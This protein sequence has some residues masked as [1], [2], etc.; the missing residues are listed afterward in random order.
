MKHLLTLSPLALTFP[1]HAI[2]SAPLR[3]NILYVVAD[4]LGYADLGVQGSI[5]VPT[6][7][8]DSIA[9][10]G[11]RFTHGYVSAPV[12]SPSRAGLI[13]GRYQTRFGH[14]LNHPMADRAPVG[15]PVEQKTAADWFKAAGYATAH[16][17]KWHLGNPNLPQF[18]PTARGFDHSVWSPGQ[19]KLPPLTLW[20]NGKRRQPT[21][22]SSTWRS[23]A[24]PP[25]TS[26]DTL[27]RHGSCTWHF[28]RRTNR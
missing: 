20:R 26:R 23:P 13:T 27:R 3:P 5:D 21:M 10:K 15:M 17:G 2:A 11:V 6:P 16:I 14:E 1:L 18:A 19:N 9:K 12:C 4:D 28:S 24:R 22:P 7:H 8:L 25:T